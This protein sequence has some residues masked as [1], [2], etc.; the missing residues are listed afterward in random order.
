MF[1][2]SPQFLSLPITLTVVS[3]TGNT[4]ILA[5]SS[6]TDLLTGKMTDVTNEWLGPG[7]SVGM[8]D[9]PHGYY[10]LGVKSGS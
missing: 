2:D 5:S 4:S 3:C 10:Y 9:V 1:S 8:V 7:I 6:Y